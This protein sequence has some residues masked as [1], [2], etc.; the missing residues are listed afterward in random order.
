M[1]ELFR[2][3]LSSS[4][5]RRLEGRHGGGGPDTLCWVTDFVGFPVELGEMNGEDCG[6]RGEIDGEWSG[7]NGWKNN[8]SDQNILSIVINYH[9]LWT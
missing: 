4:D 8:K 5:G 7:V 6:I 1:D 3:L 9:E 2:A